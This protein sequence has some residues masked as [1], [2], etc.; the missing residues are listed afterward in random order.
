MR[1]R[2]LP[3]VIGLLTGCGQKSDSPAA[4]PAGP[5][6]AQD[7][8]PTAPDSTASR[9]PQPAAHPDTTELAAAL[10]EL[11]QVLRKYSAEKRRVPTSLDELVAAG[12]LKHVPQAPPGKKFAING[13]RVEVT[14]VKQ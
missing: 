6:S 8:T 9:D 13:N 1:F 3:L 2:L 14:L 7:S 10:N 12:Y 4:K 5:V 11:T